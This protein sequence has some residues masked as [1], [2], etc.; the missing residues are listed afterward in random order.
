MSENA[1]DAVG[2]SAANPPS[3]QEAVSTAGV[4]VPPHDLPRIVDAKWKGAGGRQGFVEGGKGAARRE[5]IRGEEK[6]VERISVIVIVP[7]D[8][9]HAID[10][11]WYRALGARR[12][13]IKRGVHAAAI[14][15][16]VIVAGVIE[17]GPD[18]LARIVD[19]YCLGAGRAGQGI[20]ERGIRTAAQQEAAARGAGLVRS[21]DL[22]RGVDP[23]CLSADGGQGVSEGGVGAAA[24]KK[25]VVASVVDVIPHG[26]AHGVDAIGKGAIAG[27]RIV[28]GSVGVD[29]HDTA[30][31]V[32]VSRPERLDRYANPATPPSRVLRRG[33]QQ[34]L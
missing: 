27:Q 30:S 7:D 12:R 16:S 17:I 31:S 9:A 34:R 15:E 22:A 11:G 2:G 26:L 33:Q 19:A 29:G 23:K 6:A 4:E 25:A 20:V 8:L 24:A 1:P 3:C 21:D 5:R 13:I 18:D 32:V 28:E 10:A 14:D